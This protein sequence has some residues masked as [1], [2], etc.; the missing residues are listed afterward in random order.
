[1]R[2]PWSVATRLLSLPGR[3][4]ARLLYVHRSHHS[5]HSL[6]PAEEEAMTAGRAPSPSGVEGLASN[7]RADEESAS[8]ASPVA[9]AAGGDGTSISTGTSDTSPAMLEEGM[10]L[11]C[12]YCALSFT[13]VSAA[14]QLRDHVLC[15][16]PKRE[17]E[18]SSVTVK[19]EPGYELPSMTVKKEEP[20]DESAAPRPPSNGP[21]VGVAAF[22][23]SKC[24]MSFS[25]KEHLEKHDLVHTAAVPGAQPRPQAPVQPSADEN[26]ALRK[27]KCPEPSCGKAFKF[28]HHLKEH[29]RI[30]SGEKP[31][32]CPPLPKAVL[33]LGLLLISH[34]EQEVPHRQPQEAKRMKRG[35]G[36]RGRSRSPHASRCSPEETLSGRPRLR[37][38]PILASVGG[39]PRKRGYLQPRGAV[40][41]SRACNSRSR[42]GDFEVGEEGGPQVS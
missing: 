41:S 5:R 38:E 33:A 36:E 25:K 9:V 12:A 13:G 40:L 32:E 20:S 1:M 19:K 24:S 18:D 11:H 8:R 26:A 34:D 6:R 35:V 3:L 42:K 16:H 7:G 30:H 21:V 37:A 10:V 15:E 27:F 23:C 22:T 17:S 29:I 28:K 31:F 39:D 2:A 14:A 4:S